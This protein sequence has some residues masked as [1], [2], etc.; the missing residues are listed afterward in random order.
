[1]KFILKVLLITGIYYLIQ[2]YFPWYVVVLSPL[3][4]GFL[5]NSSRWSTFLAGFLGIALVW[6]YVI[7]TTDASNQS[8]LSSKIATMFG[9]PSKEWLIFMN[10]LLGGV[11]GG[12]AALTGLSFRKL[13]IRKK[14][15][16]Y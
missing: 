3:F 14:S 7:I 8:I 12:W 13:F 5:F 15:L 11:L 1:M 9:L 10:I 16:Y 4:I 2:P 6:L